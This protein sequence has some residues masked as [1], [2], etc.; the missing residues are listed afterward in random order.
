MHAYRRF[1]ATIATVIS[2]KDKN[3]NCNNSLAIDHSIPEVSEQ[4]AIPEVLE[5]SDPM[6]AAA[7][8]VRNRLKNIKK[9]KEILNGDGKLLDVAEDDCRKK[10]NA[11]L[12][13]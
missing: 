6:I 11:L 4:C 10:W 3:G 9:C 13:G 8:E 2:P 12:D 1:G 5:Q 7:S